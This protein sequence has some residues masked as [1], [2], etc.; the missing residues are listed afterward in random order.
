MAGRTSV[1]RA[2]NDAGVWRMQQSSINLGTITGGLDAC[3]RCAPWIGQIISFDGRTGEVT[4]PHATEERTVTVQIKGT[5]DQAR[6]AGWG[7]P[8]DRCKVVA[9]S[10]GL[11]IP[12][13]DFQYDE[14]AEKERADQRALEREI[15]AAK[16]R[17]ASAMTDTD[18]RKA[19]QD[20]RDAQA[21]M[22]DFI[23]RTGRNRQS[24]REQ[25]GFSDG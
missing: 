9:Y 6:A 3:K 8:N 11:A 4:L 1:A 14:D 16:R 22:R 25:L 21:D 23:A 10:P 20:V 7:H 5:L 13:A 12:Q 24:Y 17:E 19:T 15:R 2:F 18:R